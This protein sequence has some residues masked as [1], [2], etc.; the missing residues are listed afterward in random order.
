[1]LGKTFEVKCVDINHNGYGVSKVDGFILFTKGLLINEEAT[2]KITKLEKNFAFAEL[3]SLIKISQERVKPICPLFG[4]CGGCDLMHINYQA[5]LEY[6]LNYANQILK[7]IGK[8]NTSAKEIIKADN[9]YYY[10]N[11]TQVHYQE[12]NGKVECGFYQKETNIIAPYQDCFIQTKIAT[13]ISLIIKNFYNKHQIKAYDKNTKKGNIKQAIIRKTTN[14]E[15]M[16]VIVVNENEIP[17]SKELISELTTKVKTIKSIIQ[18]TNKGKTNKVYESSYKLLFGSLKLIDEIGD[19]KF[20]VDHNSF[21]QTNHLQTE[22]LYQKVLDYVNP[23]KADVIVDG[24]CGVGTISLLLAQKAKFVYGIEIVSE[25]IK[26]AN[27][28]AVLNDLKNVSFVIGKTEE[29]LNEIKE[30]INTIVVD[31]PRKGCDIKLLNTI[32]EKEI[33]KIVYV[34]CNVATLARDLNILK[35][36]YQIKEITFYDMFP[37]TMHIEAV[38]LLSLD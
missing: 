22:K 2:V 31:P 8:I 32:L 15:Y 9:P 19:L 27:E 20:S 38:V 26:N 13:E 35:E 33:N 14:E 12:I 23:N 11:N 28:N 34:S 7:R 21:F 36:K 16:V 25:A 30:N 1:M 6:K 29:K 17:R 4:V 5:Q 24:Y 37:N 18:I 3:V 10:R